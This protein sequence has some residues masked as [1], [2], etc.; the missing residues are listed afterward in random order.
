[1]LT[2]PTAK[3]AWRRSRA[4]LFRTILAP[5]PKL[6]ISEWADRYRMLSR[7]ASAEP[8]KWRTSRA[9]YQ[10]GILDAFSEPMVERVVVMSSAQV[11]KT[12][13]INNVAGYFMDQDPAPILV[14][15]PTLEMAE[16]WS[17]DRLAPML[18][19]TPRLRGKV[20]PVRARDSGNTLLH[21][22][23]P[24]GHLTAVGA[25]SA[26]GL[27]SRPI[28]IV[29]GDE[30]DRYPASA[31]AEGD[32]VTLATKRTATFWNRKIGL[33]STPTIKGF[34]RIEA[35]FVEG[36][37]RY[38]HVPCPDCAHLQRL[39]WSNLKWDD[40]RP[41]TAHYVCDNCG[42]CIEEAQ[43]HRML[44]AGVW[45][46]KNPGSR[47]AS[48]HLSA[49][50]SPWARWEE[51]VR[52]W[53]DSQGNPERLKVF[54]NT[55]LGETWE[56]EGE[57]IT[58]EGLRAHCSEY[59]AEVP[60]GVG[61]LVAA[62]DVQG[63]R[64]ELLVKGFGRGEESWRICHQ[65]IWGDP[66][67]EEVWAELETWLLRS[68]QH[69]A[70]AML[71][72]AAT[73]I[74][75]GGHHSEQ[76]YR[77]VAPRAGRRVWAIKGHAQPGRPVWGRPSR[78]NR[79]GA[80]NVP[81]GTDTAKDL[82]FARMKIHQASPGYMHFPA[83][84][85]ATPDSHRGFDRCDDEYLAQLASEKVV[86][87]YVKGRPVRSYEK[88]RPRNEALDLEVYALAAL[89]SLG[90]MTV[91][92]LGSFVDELNEEAQKVEEP[93]KPPEEEPPEPETQA[94]WVHSWR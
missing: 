90:S 77:F 16:A 64:L 52:E 33:F 22:N 47:I 76:V 74:D 30:I 75:T 88:V 79:F 18:R 54:V 23:F 68:W 62:V 69:E 71:Q 36:D 49:L 40:N 46:A 44:E 43:K 67:R 21:K 78:Q 6:T 63:D 58:P 72:V 14:V 56:E 28:R 51:L 27:A 37:Q 25:N 48:F 85:S 59:P 7:E 35:A 3:A 11:G 80:R 53:L 83:F 70:G 10:R 39:V 89:L 87:R 81:V 45:I 86:T 24:G 84:H 82:I 2:H 26:A 41:E 13:V 50:Y 5:P 32:P 29:L 8:G 61:L 42:V 4:A 31:G 93:Q 15:Q 55:V 12:E 1:M 9:P 57:R 38:Y 73:A 94:D 91:N 65:Q 19:D 17:K 92:S 60:A 20:A 34:S 66:G